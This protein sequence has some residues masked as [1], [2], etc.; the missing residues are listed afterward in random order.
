M[1]YWQVPAFLW[2]FKRQ[3][4]ETQAKPFT[5]GGKFLKSEATESRQVWK[6]ATASSPERGINDYVT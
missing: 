1:K 5:A 3:T 6:Y 4:N 2:L